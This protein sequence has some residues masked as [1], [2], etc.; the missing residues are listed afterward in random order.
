MR[1]IIISIFLAGFAYA[2]TEVVS[3]HFIVI[4]QDPALD[5]Y[6]QSLA[7]EAEQALQVLSEVFST[8]EKPIIINLDSFSDSFNAFASPIPRPTMTFRPLYSAN[9][10]SLYTVIVHELTHIK[11]LGY[12]E[13]VNGESG[14]LFGSNIGLIYEDIAALPPVWFIEGIAVWMESKYAPNG[15]LN[16]AGIRQLLDSLALGDN[17]PS[18]QD[19]SVADLE[20]WPAGAARYY[21]GAAFIDY[22]VQKYG[23][24]KIVD[25]LKNY[26]DSYPINSF[27]QNWQKVTGSS[28]F[29]D[30][31]NW[32]ELR[33][34]S[35]Q[36]RLEK[37]QS[38]HSLSNDGWYKT[39]L[40]FSPD[41]NHL[42]Y[43]VFNPEKHAYLYIAAYNGQELSNKRIV[44]EFMPRDISW[45]DNDH[46]VY[47]R[48][49]KSSDGGNYLDLF[50][51]DVKTGA[52]KRLSY[53]A[54]AQFPTSYD[55][56]VYYAQNLVSSGSKILKLCNGKTE[57]VVELP[58][59]DFV[60]SLA[61]SPKG[62]LAF[63][64]VYDNVEDIA[65]VQD[66]GFELITKNHCSSQPHWLTENEL[67]FVS[68]QSGIK[69]IYKINLQDNSLNRLSDSFGGVLKYTVKNDNIIYYSL[70]A[71]GVDLFRL[72][73]LQISSSF[74][75]KAIPEH[76]STRR[77]NTSPWIR[78]SLLAGC[79][80]L[81][82]LLIHSTWLW[83]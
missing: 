69:N 60:N 25:L 73:P 37:S 30:Y 15:R 24:E 36:N 6:A 75:P 77:M 83:A 11:Q 20:K 5:D 70:T 63:S 41:G 58:K 80:I 45:L 12:R 31:R 44:S 27:S 50:L 66:D 16:S 62:R 33:K 2:S 43:A 14:L 10:S 81:H 39:A 71:K 79:R 4:Y 68:Q 3:T 42:A 22:L 49:A 55:N 47:N 18:L 46:L 9:F 57:T 7:N 40:S 13:G 26:N 29:Q 51:L 54:R 8:P 28:L 59:G 64:L 32:S 34:Q 76:K 61:I 53:R 74:K 19:L 52:E 65:I 56:C 1:L 78:S 17:W 72:E 23:F 48:L 38:E 21:L 67:D 35:A 82:L